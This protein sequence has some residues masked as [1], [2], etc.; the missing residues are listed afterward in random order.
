M[1]EFRDSELRRIDL[2]L[3]LIF[4]GLLKHRKALDV[5]NELGLTQSAVSQALRRLRDIFE[6][7]LFLR[8][9]HGM[10]PT[11]LAIGLEAPV[12]AAVEA[13]RGA[14]GVARQFD[15]RQAS[16]TLKIAALDAEQA[17]T[18]PRLGRTLR[19]EAPGLSLSVLPLGHGRALQALKDSQVDLAIGVQF[20]VP[21]DICQSGLFEET[22]LVVGREQNLAGHPEIN[23]ERYCA[24]DHILTSPNG[25]LRG[26][27]DDHL[28]TIGRDR[29]VIMGF[30]SFFAALA[31]VSKTDAL[32]TLPARVATEFAPKFGLT[33]LKPPLELRGFRIGVF[34]HKRN[35]ADPRLS[36]IISKLTDL[37]GARMQ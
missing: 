10:E 1:S 4:L 13:L 2:T 30:P 31:A 36:W 26:V 27:V 11:A 3:L 25:D 15:P 33:I 20:N 37:N 17:T 5:A 22:Y 28:A 14:I 7:D 18:I 34:W 12:S 23:L 19:Q 32:L 24:H 35:Q 16:G 8:R 29:R 21:E 9:P 6:D